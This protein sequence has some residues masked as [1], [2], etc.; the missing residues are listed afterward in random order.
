MLLINSFHMVN[1]L[2]EDGLNENIR[3]NQF[4]WTVTVVTSQK[5]CK[6]H[7]NTIFMQKSVRKLRKLFITIT[8]AIDTRLYKL[9]EYTLQ[10]LLRNIKIY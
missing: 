8:T 3:L 4:D 2:E 10:D 6:K 9:S 5:N 7:T 1:F